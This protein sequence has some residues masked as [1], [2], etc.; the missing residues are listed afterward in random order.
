MAIMHK[1][2]KLRMPSLQQQQKLLTNVINP[3]GK[4]KRQEDAKIYTNLKL[5]VSLGIFH[6]PTTTN[7]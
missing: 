2:L 5:R 3:I 4:E 6:Y 7:F 1:L